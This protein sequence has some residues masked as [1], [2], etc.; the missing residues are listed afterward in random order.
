MNARLWW[1]RVAAVALL[2]L[3]SIAQAQILEPHRPKIGISVGALGMHYVFK[4]SFDFHYRGFSARVAP[5]LFYM[6]GGIS[7]RLG[8]YRPRHRQDRQLYI[9]AYYADDWFLSKTRRSLLSRQF[10]TD[11]D[12]YMLL[13]GIRYKMEP[14]NRIYAEFSVGAMY[15]VE[16]YAPVLEEPIPDRHYVYPMLEFRIGGIF[17]AHRVRHQY[18]P[19]QEKMRRQRFNVFRKKS[20]EIRGRGANV[21]AGAP[22]SAPTE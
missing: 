15:M 2:L 11:Q 3:H 4:P 21:G 6:S 5:G 17:F 19:G 13:L 12:I 18:L 8:Y 22:S 16:H 1:L 14:L 7:Q 9:H 20:Q 10:K